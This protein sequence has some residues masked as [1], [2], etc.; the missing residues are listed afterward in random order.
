MSGIVDYQ[1]TREQREL[2]TKLLT[3]DKATQGQP[4][5]PSEIVELARDYLSLVLVDAR[6]EVAHIEQL[7]QFYRATFHY[8]LSR[9]FWLG[10][11]WVPGSEG[12]LASPYPPGEVA[13]GFRHNQLLPIQTA[14]AVAERGPGVL[15]P[16]ELAL[17]L[18]NPYALWDLADLI[19][20]LLPRYWLGRMD[21]VR[22]RTDGTLWP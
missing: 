15:S 20:F 14:Q 11:Q 2:L 7:Q 12:T 8:P 1:M 17:L 6:A 9:R 21:Q 13:A 3:S 22:S 16:D 4:E 18:L 5:L 10:E 19:D